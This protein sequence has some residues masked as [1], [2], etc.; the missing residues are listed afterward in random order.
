M[1]HST[2]RIPHS[3]FRTQRGQAFVEYA[4]L[5]AVIAAALLGMQLYAKRSLQGGIKMAVD[6]MS[7]HPGDANGEQAQADGIRFESRDR[8]DKVIASVGSV[9]AR[10]SSTTAVSNQTLASAALPDGSVGTTVTTDTMNITGSLAA[11][12]PNVS[13]HTAVVLRDSRTAPIPFFEP[14]PPPPPSIGSGSAFSTGSS[15]SGD[16]SDP[17]NGSVAGPSPSDGGPGSDTG[18]AG[19]W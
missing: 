19:P 9:L 13:D 7:P 16:G 8:Q 12:G 17:G 5:F 4:I 10:D 18:G 1:R 14:P 3:A 11:I 15:P 2:L 6:R